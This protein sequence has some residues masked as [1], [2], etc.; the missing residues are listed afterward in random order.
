[1]S[2]LKISQGRKKDP[3]QNRTPGLTGR[4]KPWEKTLF[5]D[6]NGQ[7]H[8]KLRLLLKVNANQRKAHVFLA[9]TTPPE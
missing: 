1:M 7:C 6:K 9:Q 4:R 2:L 3:P 5:A 8:P